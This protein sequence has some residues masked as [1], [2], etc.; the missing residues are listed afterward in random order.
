MPD[1]KR[2]RRSNGRA[3]GYVT[4]QGEHQIA[5]RLPPE[6]FEELRVKSAQSGVS[7]NQMLR[8]AARRYL[9][10]EAAP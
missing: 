1:S 7:I 6:H 8:E 5:V 9:E 2:A 10:Q 3:R 4:E